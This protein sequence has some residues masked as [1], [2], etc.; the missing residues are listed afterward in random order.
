MSKQNG[1]ANVRFGSVAAGSLR[2][3]DSMA[4]GAAYGQK[5][6]FAR[7]EKPGARP[8]FS[9]LLLFLLIFL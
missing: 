7:Q 9:A 3:S 1:L 8:G 6:S 4:W 5:Q 2:F